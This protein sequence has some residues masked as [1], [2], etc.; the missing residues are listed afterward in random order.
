MQTFPC[1]L[2]QLAKQGFSTLH[3]IFANITRYLCKHYTLSS[4]TLHVIFA[5]I[6]RYVWQHHTL[7]FFTTLLFIV[8]PLGL[9]LPAKTYFFIGLAYNSGFLYTFAAENCKARKQT[10]L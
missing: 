8:K 4:Q 5:I 1:L 9:N 3:V 7:C 2:S 6:T 10:R